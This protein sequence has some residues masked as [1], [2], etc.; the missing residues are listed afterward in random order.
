MLDTRYA[1]RS[2]EADHARPS[3]HALEAALG[4]FAAELVLGD[5]RRVAGL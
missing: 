1:D 4:C 5:L 2:A 3:A